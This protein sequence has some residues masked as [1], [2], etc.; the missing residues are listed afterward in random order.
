MIMTGP[1]A[2]YSAARAGD[3]KVSAANWRLA[4]QGWGAIEVQEVR[5]DKRL[6][7]LAALLGAL[8]GGLMVA[9]ATRA[10]PRMM[11]GV[12]ATM[13][14]NM[15]DRMGEGGGVPWDI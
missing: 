1:A 11:S 10:V 15:A 7:V 3:G 6:Y 8:A 13:M 9:L 12:M 2:T 4:C 5:S 14:E